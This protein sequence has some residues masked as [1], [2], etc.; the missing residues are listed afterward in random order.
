MLSVENLTRYYGRNRALNGLSFSIPEGATAAF[1]GANGA[2]KTTT[3]SLVGGFLR[4]HGGVVKISGKTLGE[5]R[6]DG[7]Y[8]GLLPQ[9][10]QFFENRTVF[11]QLLLLAG[12]S[13]LNRKEARKEAQRVLE[14]AAL[15]EQA[16]KRVERL[17]HGM[18]VRLGTAQAFLCNPP[19]VLLDEPMA[20][21]DPK[22][23]YEFRDAIQQLAGET[24][25][26]ISSHEL[27]ELEEFCDYVCMIN[28]GQLVKQGPMEEILEKTSRTIL[29]IDTE[30]HFASQLQRQ[31]PK[32]TFEQREKGAIVIQYSNVKASVVHQEV[33]A[34][35][36][37][38]G[39]GILEL[40]SGS[41]LEEVFLK[42]VR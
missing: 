21:L 15:G 39:V 25:L 38:K 22:H 5:F 42:E 37:Q 3:F 18:R 31:F 8:L 30:D 34:W 36:I 13:G 2:G 9:D 33:L 20:G 23:R 7:G 11:R 24:T 35:L 12:L 16:N 40:H 1:V 6:R 4:P 29:K 28:H 41:R 19:L 27:G 17:S 32:Y 10:M 26:V 14:L